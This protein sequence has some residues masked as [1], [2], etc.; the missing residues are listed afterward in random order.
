[1]LFIIGG[2]VMDSWQVTSLCCYN[3]YYRLV[4]IGTDTTPERLCT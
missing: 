4:N 1:M 2:I 3:I